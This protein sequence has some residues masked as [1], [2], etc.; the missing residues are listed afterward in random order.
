MA[1]YSSTVHY[2]ITTSLDKS[3]ITALYSELTRLKQEFANI[4]EYRLLDS[5]TTRSAVKEI[6]R[7]EAALKKAFD[8][9]L[10]M[11]NTATLISEMTKGGNTLAKSLERL[12][13]RGTSALVQTY[14]QMMKIDTGAKQT[15]KT[16]DKLFNTIGNTV[17]WG[18]IASGF[19][20]VMNSAH[21]AVSYLGDLDES[22]TNIRLV[23][24][25]SKE[26]MREFARYANEAAKNLGASTV[27]YTDAALIYAQQGY[28]LSDQKVLADY[29]IKTANATG[30]TTSEVSEQMTSLINGFQLSV[31]D[32]GSALDVMAKVAN[33]SA[34]DLEELATATS[35][36]ASTANTLGV[37]QEQLTA[38][39]ATIVSVTRDAPE[40]VGNA[41]LLFCA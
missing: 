24:E 23:T 27:D 33:T 8:P 14:G 16:F 3:G 7:I 12:G 18:I 9:R 22:L 1:K 30:Q 10:G 21:S 4:Q 35:K 38:Q 19:Q 34:A 31:E 11:M 29:T 17:R 41:Y 36:V 20:T 37:T 40:N 13:S 15:T 2:N 28:S 26:S 6:E 32:V 25:E 5:E 39:I